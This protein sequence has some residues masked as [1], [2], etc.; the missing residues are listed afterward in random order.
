MLLNLVRLNEVDGALSFNNINLA[1]R[2]IKSPILL[3]PRKIDQRLDPLPRGV[4]CM[5]RFQG[6]LW[7]LFNVNISLSARYVVNIAL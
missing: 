6:C 7:G 4:L 1:F 2:L 5:T 3:F